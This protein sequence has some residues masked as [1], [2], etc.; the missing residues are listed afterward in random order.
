MAE[1]NHACGTRVTCL[2]GTRDSALVA[3]L[4]VLS[5][6]ELCQTRGVATADT[7]DSACRKWRAQANTQHSELVSTPRLRVVTYKSER[8]IQL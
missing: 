2:W 3:G 6:L 5:R 8:H 4:I 7:F 1:S